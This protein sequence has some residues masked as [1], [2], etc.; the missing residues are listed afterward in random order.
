MEKINIAKIV[1]G[2]KIPVCAKFSFTLP[3]VYTYDKKSDVSVSFEGEIQRLDDL[4]ILEGK[5]DLNYKLPCSKCLEEVCEN[6]S[7]DILERFS[8]NKEL[9]A[10]S[11]DDVILVDSTEILL[12]EVLYQ[13]LLLN[14][15]TTILCKEDC[16]G[17]CPSCGGN[18]NIKDCDCTVFYNSEFDDILKEFED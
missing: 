14:I 5:C 6:L 15:P 17:L 16:K 3:R 11:D 12:S 13:P 2:D 8:S 9:V 10:N 4:Y 18:K 7:L 1:S